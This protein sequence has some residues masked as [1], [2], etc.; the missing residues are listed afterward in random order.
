MIWFLFIFQ[1]QVCVS[2]ACVFSQNLLVSALTYVHI[3][4]QEHSLWDL[5]QGKFLLLLPSSVILANYYFF[6][7]SGK[8]NKWIKY[9]SAMRDYKE[10]WM[11]M[12]GHPQSVLRWPRSRETLQEYRGQETVGS[13]SGRPRIPSRNFHKIWIILL[14][15]SSSVRKKTLSKFHTI[16]IICLYM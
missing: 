6:L 7:I 15:I 11:T 8:E 14:Y 3:C 13:G 10:G 9:S 2:A 4:V 16:S 12:T 5:A 1:K